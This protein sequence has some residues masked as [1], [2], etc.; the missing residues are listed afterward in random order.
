LFDS[1]K[2]DFLLFK[3]GKEIIELQALFFNVYA[4]ARSQG[5]DRSFKICNEVGRG[6]KK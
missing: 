1:Q 5:R 3:A 2:G 6:S 4:L